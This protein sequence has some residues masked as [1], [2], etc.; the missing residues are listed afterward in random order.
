[1]PRRR[2]PLLAPADAVA[3]FAMLQHEPFH[4]ARTRR[5]A[6]SR[7]RIPAFGGFHG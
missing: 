4:A 5:R 2:P 6:Q 1:M 7:E 3:R